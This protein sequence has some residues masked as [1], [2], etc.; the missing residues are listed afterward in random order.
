MK[1]TPEPSK[2]FR[3][4]RRGVTIIYAVLIMTAL[5]MFLSLA[6]D[7][8]HAQLVKTELRRSADASAR[9]AAAFIYSDLNAG[10][11]AALDLASKNKADGVPVTVAAKDI[12]Y[13]YWEVKNKTFTKT[14]V[15]S[16]I[17]AVHV[18]TRQTV[19]MMF[20]KVLG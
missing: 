20:A 4:K 19:P 9:A 10:T 2:A 6:V 5:T 18:T 8:G 14:S 13:G 7:Y 15:A 1:K 17:N 11:A 16:A 3:S 12:E